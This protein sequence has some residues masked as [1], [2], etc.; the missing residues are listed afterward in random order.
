MHAHRY[1]M[2]NKPHTPK[3]YIYIEFEKKNN[4]AFLIHVRFKMIY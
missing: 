4:F 3:A 2:K 1:D